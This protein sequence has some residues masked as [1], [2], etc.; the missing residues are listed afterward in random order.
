MMISKMSKAKKK[1][2]VQQ[3]KEQLQEQKDLAEKYLE[4]LQYLQADFENYRKIAEKQNIEIVKRANEHLISHLLTVL[5]DFDEVIA[6][7]KDEGIKSVHKKFTRVLADAGLKPIDAEGKFDH[8]Y[9][10]AIAS[11]KSKKEEGT[12][13]EV[14]QKGYMLNDRVIRHSKVKVS[15]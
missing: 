11:E 5:D 6:K 15:G 4:Q 9:H 7:S 8:Y 12:I 10:E 1:D 2:K 14:L 13:L 3:L